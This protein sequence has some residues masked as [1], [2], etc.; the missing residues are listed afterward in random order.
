MAL[1]RPEASEQC[2]LRS[3]RTEVTHGGKGKMFRGEA[4]TGPS[5]KWDMVSRTFTGQKASWEYK[6]TYGNVKCNTVSPILEI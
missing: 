2:G 1:D 3:R 5:S 6:H 4:S